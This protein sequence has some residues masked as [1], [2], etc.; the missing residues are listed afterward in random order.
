MCFIVFVLLKN[1][2][3]EEEQKRQK[4]NEFQYTYDVPQNPAQEKAPTV[5]EAEEEDEE[6][7][8]SPNLDVP[9]DIAIVS[10]TKF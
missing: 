4:A 2:F 3:L 1:V 10:Y 9:V 7:V 6:Y 5:P 8:P